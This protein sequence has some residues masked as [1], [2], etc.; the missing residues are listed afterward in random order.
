MF[1]LVLKLMLCHYLEI[2]IISQKV[3]TC[4]WWP[5]TY[6]YIC[7]NHLFWKIKHTLSWPANLAFMLQLKSCVYMVYISIMLIH[8]LIHDISLAGSRKYYLIQTLHSLLKMSFIISKN[9]CDVLQWAS[10]RYIV[11]LQVLNIYRRL[12]FYG[13]EWYI[14]SIHNI[15]IKDGIL[16]SNCTVGLPCQYCQTLQSSFHIGMVYLLNTSG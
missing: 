1:T 8:Y 10:C 11:K 12:M 4:Y 15:L 3:C 14:F 9:D 16:K 7:L 13:F 2:S 5:F 6:R